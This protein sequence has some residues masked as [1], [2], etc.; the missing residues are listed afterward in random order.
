MKDLRKLDIENVARI[1][2]MFLDGDKFEDVLLDKLSIDY[3]D[4]NYN[5]EYFSELKGTL[6]K[7]EKINPDLNVTGVLWQLRPDNPDLVVPVIVGNAF[8][9]E[10]EG[11]MI[12]PINQ[13]MKMTFKT[14]VEQIKKRDNCTSYYY[15]L[16]N[17]NDIIVGVLEL[18]CDRPYRSDI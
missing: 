13:E 18:L 12:T 16:R 7:I 11:W 8:P 17:S 15:P 3:D 2:L 6:L 4:V 9:E 5:H 14:G 1:G 10:G